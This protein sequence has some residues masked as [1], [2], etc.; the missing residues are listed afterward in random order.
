MKGEQVDDNWRRG[1]YGGGRQADT[2]SD[3]TRWAERQCEAGD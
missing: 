3:R 1:T 2:P